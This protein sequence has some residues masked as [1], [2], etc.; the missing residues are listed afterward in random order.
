V[1]FRQILHEDLGCASYFVASRGEALVVDPK[2]EI[3]DYLSVAADAVAEVRHVLETH[4]HADHVSGR[5]K[6]MRAT[7]ATPYVP[8]DPQRPEAGGLRDGDTLSI[9][10]VTL[11]VIAAPGHRP[12]HLAF[13]L[14]EAGTPKLLLS[15]D[16]LLVGS[17]ARPDLAVDAVEGS[18][19]LW[20]TVKRLTALGESVEVW[21]AHVGASLCA[22]G[23]MT[24]RTHST[25]GEELRTNVQLSLPDEDAFVQEQTRSTPARPSR[26]SQVVTF[27]LDGAEEPN[28]VRQLDRGALAELIAAGACVLDVRSPELF[29][30]CHIDGALNL[31]AVG[32]SL[33]NRAGWATRPEELI[34][35]LSQTRESGKRVTSLLR[36]AGVW[37]V[38]G[39]AVADPSAWVADGLPVSSSR[40]LAPAELPALLSAGELQLI[41]VRDPGE[42]HSGHI[43][44]STHLPL[45]RLGDGSQALPPGQRPLAVACAAG[46]RAALA[47]SI[48]RRRGHNDVVRVSGGV[49]DLAGRG[50]ALIAG[51]R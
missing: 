18:R 32:R 39:A 47:A 33:G 42:W 11:T 48:L 5:R 21:P 37:N 8:L 13:L 28:P 44:G 29:D 40:A 12:E 36:A 6:L 46:A 25:I 20:A 51:D 30:Q 24:E 19:A 31:A 16:S 27:N 34:V 4:F 49:P 35:V 2:W 45:H 1:F 50:V 23:T 14:T 10:Y 41:D 22:S 3:D 7:G 26:V 38:A 17:L 9:G 15:G 43:A